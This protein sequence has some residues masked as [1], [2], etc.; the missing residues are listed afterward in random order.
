METPTFQQK[1][2]LTSWVEG[3]PLAFPIYAES[4]EEAVAKAMEIIRISNC[5]DLETKSDVDGERDG[6][7]AII[8]GGRAYVR[9]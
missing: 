4:K 3:K 9:Q 5:Y 2:L 8:I 7:V 1:F 6:H